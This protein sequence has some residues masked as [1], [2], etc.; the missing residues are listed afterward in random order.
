MIQVSDRVKEAEQNR[1]SRAGAERLGFP[2]HM[3]GNQLAQVPA[4]P[5][6]FAGPGQVPAPRAMIY[7]HLRRPA[8]MPGGPHMP[9]QPYPRIP[10]HGVPAQYHIPFNVQAPP[11]AP[12]LPQFLGIPQMP[13]H[14]VPAGAIPPRNLRVWY[15]PLDPGQINYLPR[16]HHPPRGRPH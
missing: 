11:R 13:H 6:L 5:G 10:I 7:P 1:M 2:F 12:G 16:N 8:Q 14:A 9:H 4:G 15:P 3:V